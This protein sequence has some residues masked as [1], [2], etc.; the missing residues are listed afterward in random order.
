[1]ISAPC[2]AG[3]GDPARAPGGAYPVLLLPDDAAMFVFKPPPQMR[4]A[5]FTPDS[6]AYAFSYKPCLYLCVLYLAIPDK[7]EVFHG[8]R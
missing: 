6:S 3:R 4:N 5:H 8:W 1:M 2:H 7:K